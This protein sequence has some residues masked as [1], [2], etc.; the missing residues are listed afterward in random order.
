[1]NEEE[2]FQ[3]GAGLR[4]DSPLNRSVWERAVLGGSQDLTDLMKA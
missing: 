1:M 3:W 4:P 2:A